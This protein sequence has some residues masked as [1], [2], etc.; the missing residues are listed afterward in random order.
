[1]SGKPVRRLFA[2]ALCAAAVA[3]ALAVRAA[4][5]P[6]P[7]TPA[8]PPAESGLR[9]VVGPY[10][11]YATRTSI[12]VMAE[13]DAPTTCRVEYGTSTPLRSGVAPGS[14]D[15][16]TLHEVTLGGLEPRTK[17]FY[18]VT[19]TAADGRTLA[20]P[21]LTFT[22]AA[23]PA[24]AFS[25]A[26]I[27]D[28]QKN[29]AM[30]GRLAR[31]IWERRP[32]FVLHMG[33]VVD[34][35]PDPKEWTDELF[36]PCRDLFARVPVYP[37][38]G[39]HER[40]HAH[41]YKYF[42]LPKPEYYYSFKYGNAEFFSLDTNKPVGPGS[43][44]Y[45]WLDAALAASDARWKVCFHHHPCYSSDAD[46]YGNTWTGTSRL[47]DKNA[48]Q[49]IALYEKYHVDLALNGHIHLYER[50]WPVRSGAVDVKSGVTYV[51][52][53]GGG[54]KLEDVQPTPAFFKNQGRMDYHYCYVTVFGGQLDFKAFDRDNHLFDQFA[55]RKE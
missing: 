53:G 4:P 48:Q 35:G 50:T 44:Q 45:K 27:G 31:Y 30:T 38:I 1:M 13:T 10:L 5:G 49:L 47:G 15:P 23:E 16:S 8:Q 40:N 46:D 19:C 2:A 55:L 41:Y 36:G 29:P 22:T 18:R 51:T 12:V 42:S 7:Q 34:N 20:S 33:D 28:T 32:H 39:N 54:G 43:E 3:L 14:T 9:F 24:D 25:F 11:Q 52:S 37:C 6:A 26:I 21:L 17:Y